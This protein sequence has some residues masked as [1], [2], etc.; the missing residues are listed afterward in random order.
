MK[1]SLDHNFKMRGRSLLSFRLV[2]VFLA[3]CFT[4]VA[5]QAA[6]FP[7]LQQ[8]IDAGKVPP[9]I[10]KQ[11]DQ[12]GGADVIVTLDDSDVRSMAAG[13]RRNLG[14]RN[15][16]AAILSEKALLYRDKKEKVLA[17]IAA[18]SYGVLR[19]YG[20]LPVMFMKVDGQSLAALLSMKEVRAVGENRAFVP[21]LAQSLPLIHQPEAFSAGAAGAGT[22]VAVVDSGVYYDNGSFGSCSGGPGSI[23]C[24]VAYEQCIATGGCQTDKKHGTN[25]SGIVLGV[26]PDTEILSLDVFRSSDGFAYD[27]DILA[28]LN[29]VLGEQMDSGSPYY[30]KIEAVNMS[31]GGQRYYD[32][33]PADSLASAITSLKD[34]GILTAVAS[35]NSGYTDSISSP[36]CCPD[37]VS[38]GAVYDSDVGPKEWCLNSS[39]TSTCTDTTTAAD[40]VTCF[41]NSASFLT[42]LAPGAVIDA[43]GYTFAGTSQATPFV[44]GAAA[45]IKGQYSALTVGDVVSSMTSSGVLITDPRNSITKPR[46]DLYAA[47]LAAGSHIAVSPTSKDFGTVYVGSPLSQTF[48]ISNSGVSGLGIQT[49]SVG[50]ASAA[51]FVLQNDLCSSHTLGPG[52]SCTADVEFDPQAAGSKSAQ[53]SV[54]SDDLANPTLT[55]SLAGSAVIPQYTLTVLKAGTG[56]GTVTSSPAGI[57]CGGNCSV[58]Y[59]S[60]TSVTLTANPGTYSTFT[61]WTGG[62]CSTGTCDITMTADTTVTATF[63]MTRPTASFT[64]T[65]TSG[66]APLFVSFTDTSTNGPSSWLWTFGDGGTSTVQNPTHNYTGADTYT[67]TLTVTNAGGSDVT[68]GT[69]NVSTCSN[70]AVRLVSGATTTD[71]SDLVTAVGD[72]G[73]GDIIEAQALDFTGDLSFGNNVT[74]EGGYGCDYLANPA[75]TTVSGS[76]TVQNGTL[77]VEGIAIQ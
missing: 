32:Q 38:V 23:G 33:C 73:N 2:P 44:A 34:A 17:G 1:V 69:I 21:F 77:T 18:R 64:S 41:S 61:G 26:A 74:L 60:G 76:L 36:A 11:I 8:F 10:A 37:A 3:I 57:S 24:E 7:D 15:D 56:T 45:V 52:A 66:A 54:P 70:S 16:N 49:L 5:V 63:A 35:G 31:L 42:M 50:G 39:C 29:W 62:G 28:A 13:M 71:Y 40:Q 6:G 68:T 65:A 14:V 72:A 9:G 22:F 25:V 12:S 59:D 19:D 20:N 51:D 55:V 75:A 48:T 46:L 4:G 53:L 47:L 27:N 58:S 43:G 67:V 30:G